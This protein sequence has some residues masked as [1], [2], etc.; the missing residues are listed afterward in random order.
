MKVANSLA[1]LLARLRLQEKEEKEEGSENNGDK[2]VLL[3]LNWR[4][5]HGGGWLGGWVNREA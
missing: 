2:G 4:V 5:D 1:S 3:V